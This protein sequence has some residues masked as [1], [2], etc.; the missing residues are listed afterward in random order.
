M[1]ILIINYQ[2]K[3]NN[4]F[5]FCNLLLNFLKLSLRYMCD[6]LLRKIRYISLF[7]LFFFFI[8]TSTFAQQINIKGKVTDETGGGL[9]GVNVLLKGTAVGTTTGTDG[10]YSIMEYILLMWQMKMDHW[11][12]LYWLY[13]PGNS[14]RRTICD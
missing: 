8:L 14:H 4:Y 9:A 13:Y 6:F 10:I 7:C 1:N 2:G 3:P 11:F 5:F 12:F